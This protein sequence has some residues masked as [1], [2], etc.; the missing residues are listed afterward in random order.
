MSDYECSVLM[1]ETAANKNVPRS[2]TTTQNLVLQGQAADVLVM[3]LVRFVHALI[4]G[5]I[6]DDESVQSSFQLTVQRIDQLR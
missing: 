3:S 1:V 5:I 6:Y 2:R 4:G